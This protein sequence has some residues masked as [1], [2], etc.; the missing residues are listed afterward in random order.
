[1]APIAATPPSAMPSCTTLGSRPLSSSPPS[2]VPQAMRGASGPSTMPKAS[3][4]SAATTT[5]AMMRGPVSKWNPSSG[6]LP[7]WPG[8]RWATR[9]IRAPTRRA[10]TTYHHDGVLR[11]R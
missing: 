8:S 6:P 2:A 7:V 3:V 1:M 4:A 10:T 5:D 11:P 9:T